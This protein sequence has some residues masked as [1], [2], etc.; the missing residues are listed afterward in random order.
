VATLVHAISPQG[1]VAL[2]EKLQGLAWILVPYAKPGLPLTKEILARTVAKTQV[3]ILENH[4]LICAGP[5]VDAVSD[6][7]KDV[8]HRLQMPVIAA[9]TRPQGRP[10]PGFHWA[11]QSWLAM[12]DLASARATAGTYY[13]DHVVFLGPG[14]A[15]Q[16]HDGLPP[17][18][19]KPGQGVLLRDGATASQ[20]AMLQCLQDVLSRVPSDWVLDPLGAAA[21]AD[22]LNWDAEKYRQA[23][24]ART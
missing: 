1:R 19:L 12:D 21:E 5:T 17:A 14:L 3:I 20:M 11:D 16:D 9:P 4:G 8:E 6:L 13:P 18:I 15:T 23:L 7:I 10:D 22:L 24:A 2:T